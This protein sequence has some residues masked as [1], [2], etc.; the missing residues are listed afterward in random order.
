M[1][2]VYIQYIFVYS[3]KDVIE[4]ICISEGGQGQNRLLDN[5]GLLCV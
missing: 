1:Y 5:T 2:M 3:Y 4:V